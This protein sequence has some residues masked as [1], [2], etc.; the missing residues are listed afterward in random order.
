MALSVKAAKDHCGYQA[1]PT[2]PV[3]GNC[4]AFV[5]DFEKVEKNLRCVDHG[6][7]TKKM[8]TC[9]LWRSGAQK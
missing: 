3:C 1:K 2:F 4:G 9:R 8:A 7:T 6:F 5:S